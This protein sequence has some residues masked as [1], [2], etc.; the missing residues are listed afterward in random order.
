M[1]LRAPIA[2]VLV[3]LVMSLAGCLIPYP[4]E[5][6]PIEVNYPPYFVKGT[7]S[8]SLEDLIEFDPRVD[9]DGV[10]F[11]VVLD[12]PNTSDQLAFRWFINYNA[13]TGAPITQGVLPPGESGGISYTFEPCTHPSPA[14][15]ANGDVIHRMDLFVADRAFLQ[16]QGTPANQRVAAGTGT[17]QFTW[18]VRL[19][20]TLCSTRQP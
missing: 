12:D 3:L 8:P 19:D 18:F 13:I 6:R 2:A 5:E 9:V 7:L 20:D 14:V 4:I 1:D 16:T 10:T 11:R 17:L 15:D